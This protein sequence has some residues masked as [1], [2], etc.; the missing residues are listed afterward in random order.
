VVVRGRRVVSPNIPHVTIR[1]GTLFK[2]F[3]FLM[4]II[5]SM[6]GRIIIILII[7]VNIIVISVAIVLGKTRV[8]PYRQSNA[9]T[10]YSINQPI[11]PLL[12]TWFVQAY[13][14]IHTF[15]RILL[16]KVPFHHR[17]QSKHHWS[18]RF[19]TLIYSRSYYLGTSLNISWRV[20]RFVVSSAMSTVRATIRPSCL[21]ERNHLK[22]QIAYI[23]TNFELYKCP[24]SV[25]KGPDGT[26]VTVFPPHLNW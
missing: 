16:H 1:T 23:N 10:K 25:Q 11:T 19:D 14:Y 12:C 20:G 9:C 6:Y 3:L 15:S 24:M 18:N 13:I 5:I 2:S 4:I 7:V 8:S 17:K 22:E 21:C 26:P